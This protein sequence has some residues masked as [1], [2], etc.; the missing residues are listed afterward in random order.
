LDD[1]AAGKKLSGIA[2]GDSGSSG[3]DFSGYDE[4]DGAKVTEQCDA[5]EKGV[6]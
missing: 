1:L 3:P 5:F 6:I 4:M 2:G